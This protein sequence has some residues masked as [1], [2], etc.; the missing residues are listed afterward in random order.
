MYMLNVTIIHPSGNTSIHTL[1][2]ENRSQALLYKYNLE[3][4]TRDA[5]KTVISQPQKFTEESNEK[6]S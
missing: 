6:S 2:F 3:R 4:E 1:L 5:F